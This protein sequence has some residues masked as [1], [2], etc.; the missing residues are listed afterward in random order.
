MVDIEQ[1]L[2]DLFAGKPSGIHTPSVPESAL[3][4]LAPRMPLLAALGQARICQLLSRFMPEKRQGEHLARAASICQRESRQWALI[5]AVE[6]LLFTYSNNLLD[7][8]T[9]ESKPGYSRMDPRDQDARFLDII[10]SFITIKPVVDML[11]RASRTTSTARALLDRVFASAVRQGRTDVLKTLVTMGLDMAFQINRRIT[12]YGSWP[13]Y[14]SMDERYLDGF[15]PYDYG[16]LPINLAL[17]NGHATLVEFLLGQG[18][19][20]THYRS[21]IFPQPTELDGC[22]LW[23]AVSGT[24]PETTASLTSKILATQRDISEKD[25]LPSLEILHKGSCTNEVIV[26]MIW[27]RVRELKKQDPEQLKEPIGTLILA[28]RYGHIDIVRELVAKIDDLDAA[29]ER[30]G[31]YWH[32][33]RGK[34]WDPTAIMEAAA[35]GSVDMCKIF[36]DA[37]AKPNPKQAEKASALWVAAAWGNADV[38]RLLCDHQADMDREASDGHGYWTALGASI[39]YKWP[40]VSNLLLD[41]GAKPSA[42]DLELAVAG[43]NTKL[44]QRLV[45]KDVEISPELLLAAVE[46]GDAEMVNVLSRGKAEWHN[47]WRDEW[48]TR[49]PLA[50]AILFR[51]HSLVARILEAS[52]PLHSYDPAALLAATY[53]VAAQLTSDTSTFSTVLSGR[54]ESPPP[55]P[56]VKS[57]EAHAL[58]VAVFYGGEATLVSL[59]EA[60]LVLPEKFP[61]PPRRRDMLILL[62]FRKDLYL[63]TSRSLRDGSYHSQ[64][65]RRGM[66]L[67]GVAAVG[68]ESSRMVD[69]LL[70]RKYVPNAKDL[71]GAAE[72]ATLET[73]KRLL[74][75]IPPDD[76]QHRIHLESALLPVFIARGWMSLVEE[77]LNKDGVDVNNMAVRAWCLNRPA[78]T[79]LQAAARLGDLELVR[80]LVRRKA[81]VNCPASRDRGATTLQYAALAGHIGIA[82]FLVEKGR[83]NCNAPGAERGGR[84]ALESAAEHGHIDMLHYLLYKGGAGTEG[85]YREAYVHAVRRAELGNHH[86]AVKLLRSHRPWT[87]EDDKIYSVGLPG[88][89]SCRINKYEDE[90][91]SEEEEGEVLRHEVATGDPAEPA[92]PAELQQHQD[93]TYGRNTHGRASVTSP[94]EQ[95]SPS[96]GPGRPEEGTQVCGERSAPRPEM[97]PLNSS[98]TGGPVATANDAPPDDDN[99]LCWGSSYPGT[100]GRTTVEPWMLSTDREGGTLDNEASYAGGARQMSTGTVREQEESAFAGTRWLGDPMLLDAEELRNPMP[101]DAGGLEVPMP[102]DTGQLE[103]SEFVDATGGLQDG[104]DVWMA[105]FLV[106]ESSG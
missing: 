14:Y 106:D 103:N 71:A 18:A 96:A 23:F 40:R 51:H 10:N 99:L 5:T 41:L 26:D 37:G 45:T 33:P 85:E 13:G 53:A 64:W 81:E 84:T 16:V 73:V 43:G 86:E 105:E 70:G 102:G 44:V 50:T 22:S 101:G 42:V 89:W 66:S 57:L 36:L 17:R 79:A 90:T 55:D 74:R 7:F 60:G 83:A 67:L 46:G 52:L 4:P 9:H 30:G 77:I 27:E 28:I 47:C 72:W 65:I 19:T 3:A 94:R 92:E 49:S 68:L 39:Y 97:S 56:W 32:T 100:S 62:W 87:E 95:L 11:I 1:V 91:D 59:L 93:N 48:R 80:E 12:T 29:W 98:C 104:D 25:L 38:V 24:D 61:M 75:E 58:I 2:H 6:I 78:M 31:I 8:F 34:G 82:R 63:K 21:L 69:F 54:R 35:N 20:L 15:S 88:V 76:P